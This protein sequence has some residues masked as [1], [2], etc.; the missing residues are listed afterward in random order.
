MGGEAKARKRALCLT[1]YPLLI[2]QTKSAPKAL[3]GL[4]LLRLEGHVAEK[5]LIF[6]PRI[7]FDRLIESVTPSAI[8]AMESPCSRHHSANRIN[9]D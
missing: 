9:G 3:D 2:A 8:V 5:A 7:S 6:G 4:Y 1:I